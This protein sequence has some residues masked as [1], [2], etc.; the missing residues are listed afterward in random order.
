M[1]MSKGGIDKADDIPAVE[2]TTEETPHPADEDSAPGPYTGL[3]PD[4]PPVSTTQPDVP[5]AQSPRG[6]GG[7][8]ARRGAGDA[9]GRGGRRAGRGGAEEVA[10]PAEEGRGQLAWRFG[11]WRLTGASPRPNLGGC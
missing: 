7:C 5:I 10:R 4:R 8:A 1:A 2:T 3:S 6:W 11:G 9:G